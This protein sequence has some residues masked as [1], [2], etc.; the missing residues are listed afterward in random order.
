MGIRRD[1]LSSGL[2][3]PAISPQVRRPSV[4]S[5]LSVYGGARASPGAIIAKYGLKPSPFAKLV[6][7]GFGEFMFK[8]DYD[9]ILALGK[10][11]RAGFTAH[12]D[13]AESFSS[14]SAS[15]PGRC[16]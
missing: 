15:T 8:I 1:G 13:T 3:S 14:A 11:G 5:T 12:P 10:I 2:S 4:H 6:N 7:W 16:I 9:I